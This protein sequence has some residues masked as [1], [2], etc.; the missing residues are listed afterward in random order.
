MRGSFTAA[1]VYFNSPTSE[2]GSAWPQI[3]QNKSNTLILF[4]L[5]ALLVSSMSS[6]VPK[7]ATVST[8]NHPISHLNLWPRM[9]QGSG[10]VSDTKPV[11]LSV[12]RLQCGRLWTTTPTWMQFSWL[13]DSMLKVTPPVWTR[14][15]T[16]V[17]IWI[18]ART[19]LY[20]FF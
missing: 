8:S 5:R 13:R 1:V 20:L 2:A 4:L 3:L 18:D 10:L 9:V 19:K 12:F 15:V 17:H 6:T 16:I 14:G 11:C 7:T